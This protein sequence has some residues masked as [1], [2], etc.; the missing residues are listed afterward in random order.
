[1]KTLQQISPALTTRFATHSITRNA[2]RPDTGRQAGF[3]LIELLV[4]IAIIAILIGLLLPAVQKVRE[5]AAKARCT[6]NLRQIGIAV[7]NYQRANGSLP[8]ATGFFDAIG[9]GGQYPNNQKDGFNH[10][11][12]PVRGCLSAKAAAPGRTA[13]VDGKVCLDGIPH[14]FPNP[15]A[16]SGRFQMLSNIGKRGAEEIGG[17][18]AQMPS[19]WRT[20]L[21]RFTDGT[22]NTIMFAEAFRNLDSDGN[23]EATLGD[24]FGRTR[25]EPTGALNR[26]L[27]IIRQ[28]MQ[29]GVAGE[30]WTTMPGVTFNQLRCRVPVFQCPS[31]NPY[32][33]RANTSDGFSSSFSLSGGHT[34]VAQFAFADG[35]VRSSQGLLSLF[36]AQ[37]YFQH[38][39]FSEEVSGDF[40]LESL[41]ASL[42]AGEASGPVLMS[43]YSPLGLSRLPAVDSSDPTGKTR[44]PDA[45]PEV[46]AIL[47][48]APPGDIG[49]TGPF[50]LAD[51]DGNALAGVLIGL[52]MPDDRGE[53]A[54]RQVLKSLVITV[55]GLGSLAGSPGI[56]DA[57]IDWREGFDGPFRARLRV[58]PF[59]RSVREGEGRPR[60]D[61]GPD[62]AEPER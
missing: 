62:R 38:S 25:T 37:L 32:D 60:D 4:V 14:I 41:S 16:D 2:A 52:L 10:L 8:P 50:L 40:S 34:G 30:D 7:N 44:A 21:T 22:S 43:P 55:Q 13:A 3:T 56:G 1:M 36:N 45:A 23:G 49:F 28:E 20:V 12:D 48:P 17:L 58:S 61:D 47:N 6:N 11:W 42:A 19:S 53:S 18:V 54:G 31:N 33:L 9:L 35:S 24:I 29:L 27:P 5:A 15:F 26:L 59:L 57:T 39:G 51:Q 46:A